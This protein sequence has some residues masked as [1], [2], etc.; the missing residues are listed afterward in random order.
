[1]PFVYIDTLHPA[2][3]ELWRDSGLELYGQQL[4]GNF[5]FHG[6]PSSIRAMWGRDPLQVLRLSSTDYRGALTGS[7]RCLLARNLLGRSLGWNITHVV[8]TFA[9]GYREVQVLSPSVEQ[10]MDA[11]RVAGRAALTEEQLVPFLERQ[12]IHD[13][14]IACPYS[15]TAGMLPAWLR[16]IEFSDRLIEGD[17]LQHFLYNGTR[18][19]SI[20]S[21]MPDMGEGSA[22]VSPRWTYR[23]LTLPHQPPVA[24]T[25]APTQTGNG[26]YMLGAPSGQAAAIVR[27]LFRQPLVPTVPSAIVFRSGGDSAHIL[28]GWWLWECM[29]FHAM[30][31]NRSVVGYWVLT[32]STGP[33]DQEVP[34]GRVFYLTDENGEAWALGAVHNLRWCHSVA[35][36]GTMLARES[37]NPF[38]SRLQLAY[39]SDCFMGRA[40]LN[41]IMPP[42]EITQR[43]LEEMWEILQ[44][45]TARLPVEPSVEV[46]EIA[47]IPEVSPS[48]ARFGLEFE[49]HPGMH[50]Q[51]HYLTAIRD[52][53]SPLGQADNV[54]AYGYRHS[55][56]ASWELKTDSSCGFEVA[57][58]ALRWNQWNQVAAVMTALQNAG[59]IVTA[60]CGLHVHHETIGARASTLRRLLLMWYVYESVWFNMVSA[61]RRNSRY[62]LPLRYG[63]TYESLFHMLQSNSNDTMRQV[64][65]NLSRY[66]GLNA[67]TWWASGRVEVRIHHGTLQPNLVQLWTALTQN[68]VEESRRPRNFT[69]IERIL[70]LTQEEQI[71][72]FLRHVPSALRPASEALY[73]REFY[74]P[75]EWDGRNFT[76]PN[77]PPAR[78]APGNIRVRSVETAA[79]NLYD[80]YVV[81][82]STSMPSGNGSV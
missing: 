27:D 43:W 47:P 32:N 30:Q 65:N 7:F 74:Q 58:P 12:A 66:R 6:N 29:Q 5:D 51:A 3:P 73:Q 40:W 41:Q 11:I 49:F 59:A 10:L 80:G 36:S 79:N 37:V 26:Q 63:A 35:N 60:R 24:R 81:T 8:L 20:L 18:I 75:L 76:Q 19:A 67:T 70:S 45:I 69:N 2:M 9:D 42:D 13:A 50:P 56:G 14:L 54:F 4:G 61:S 28:A 31:N 52:A 38:T 82:S 77:S 55:N 72:R 21:A 17:R 23:Y 64:V 48:D 25:Y 44:E 15:N 53:L 22:R 57:S 46:Q 68:F 62:C 39:S 71:E 33:S 78:Q 16:S 1:M 34:I